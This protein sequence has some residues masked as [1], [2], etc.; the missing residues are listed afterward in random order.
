M[1]LVAVIYPEFSPFPGKC[2]KMRKKGANF[3][4]FFG[5]IVEN[6]PFCIN[7]E[8]PDEILREKRPF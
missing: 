6:S 2:L 1:K 3:G 8:F 4:L 7:V 5:I